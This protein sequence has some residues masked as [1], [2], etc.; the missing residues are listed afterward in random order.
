MNKTYI[1]PP[2]E[3]LFILFKPMYKVWNKNG[4]IDFPTAV[5][6]INLQQTYIIE[7]LTQ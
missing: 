3:K 6:F 7:I 5:R 4:Y 1:N 2:S